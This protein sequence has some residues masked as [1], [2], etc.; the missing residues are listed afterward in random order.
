LAADEKAAYRVREVPAGQAVQEALHT[1]DT[2]P[3]VLP[4]VQSVQVVAATPEL[5]LARQLVQ[6]LD[7]ELAALVPA[8]HCEHEVLPA[9]DE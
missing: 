6:V 7:P 3:T 1:G 8:V 4:T 2:K 5:V 9:T